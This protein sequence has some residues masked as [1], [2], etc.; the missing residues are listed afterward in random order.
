MNPRSYLFVPADNAERLAKSTMRGADALIIDLEDGVSLANKAT[1]RRN[2]SAWLDS[3]ET[4]SE[5]WVRINEDS[6]DLDVEAVMHAKVTG[7]IPSKSS[8][9]DYV[10]RVGEKM[11]YYEAKNSITRQI[12]IMPLVESA[13]GILNLAQIAQCPRVTRLMLGEQDLRADLGLPRVSDGQVLD[14]ARNS[15]IFACA[16]AGIAAPIASV[17]VDFNDLSKF[18]EGTIGFARRGFYGRACIHPAQ[19]EIANRVFIPSPED[20]AWAEDIL[21]KFEAANGGATLDSQGKMIDEAVAKRARR[22]LS[23]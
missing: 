20:I 14:F 19:I 13:E 3:V 22:I 17:S 10:T 5:I 6:V 11:S 15:A 16:A 9:P 21:A 23:R 2:A 4:H 1:A 7:I 8:T 12:S 18:E